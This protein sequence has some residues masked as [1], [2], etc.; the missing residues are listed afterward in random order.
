M[1]ER[2]DALT[3]HTSIRTQI[4]ALV[5]TCTIISPYGRL[6]R[7]NIAL[8]RLLHIYHQPKWVS[9]NSVLQC[10]FS[11]EPS[12]SEICYCIYMG[13]ADALSALDPERLTPYLDDKK[14]VPSPEQ[15]TQ[16]AQTILRH[17][18]SYF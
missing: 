6:R 9:S 5:N 11:S 16:G 2:A 12:A 1:W 4:L 3:S 10:M 15:I 8:E 17:C 13:F 18:S 14:P 7:C